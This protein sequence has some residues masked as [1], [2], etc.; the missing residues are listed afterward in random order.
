MLDIWLEICGRTG[1]D[2][3]FLNLHAHADVVR[4]AISRRQGGPTVILSEE[5]E[6]LGSAGTLLENR[7]WIAGEEEFWVFYA[8]VL[9]NTNLGSMLA[10]H[11]SAR[12]AATIGVCRAAEPKRCGI[13]VFNQDSIVLDFVEKPENPKSDWAFSGLLIGTPDLLDAIPKKAPAD[14]GMHVLPQLAGRMLAY[15]ISEYLTDIGTMKN[16][17]AAQSQ[18]P[19]L[20]WTDAE[21]HH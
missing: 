21:V 2:E 17:Q 14:L 4:T 12:P 18:W 20:V 11:R 19:G 13:A 16:Y 3:V 15:P 7:A 8:D 6:L 1:I 9:T 5:R 10:F